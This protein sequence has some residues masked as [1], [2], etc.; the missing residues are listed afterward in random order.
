MFVLIFFHADQQKPRMADLLAEVKVAEWFPFG[1]ELT[2]DEE[3]MFQ[4]K[5]NH[6]GDVK[7][8]LQDTFILWLNKCEKPTWQKVINALRKFEHN[9]LACKLEH[10][11]I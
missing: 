9:Q 11:Y 1:L 6:H 4:I 3:E 5:A 7:G 2:N 10:R 8:A